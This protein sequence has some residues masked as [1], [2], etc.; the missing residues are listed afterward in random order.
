MLTGVPRASP[1]EAAGSWLTR[2][3]LSQGESVEDLAKGLGVD[4]GAD[5]DLTI[6][7]LSSN[8]LA[9]FGI[10]L[11]DLHISRRVCQ[12]FAASGCER[13]R[14]LLY[15]ALRRERYRFCPVCLYQSRNP[16]VPIHWRFTAWR[17][18]PSHQCMMEDY[19]PHCDADLLLP[20][21]L[22]SGGPRRLGIAHV[23]LCNCCAEPLSEV[24]PVYIGDEP[25]V[26]DFGSTGLI[27][28]RNG[29]ALLAALYFG[30]LRIEGSCRA[31][32]LSILQRLDGDGLFA[33]DPKWLSASGVRCM[34]MRREGMP[35]A[36]NGT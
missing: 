12:S 9:R 3:A 8:K 17:V 36:A 23:G 14:F 25:R 19:C 11:N 4:L 18:C 21:N 5:A 16:I 6:G 15:G 1:W 20:A 30:E 2:V 28:L 26:V 10:D 34:R 7:C 35:F 32:P 27:H 33:N 22:I 24:E 13:R 31:E 29:R